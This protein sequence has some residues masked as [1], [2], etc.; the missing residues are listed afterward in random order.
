VLVLALRAY[1]LAEPVTVPEDLAGLPEDPAAG[2][3]S[4]P[5]LSA[6]AFEARYNGVNGALPGGLTPPG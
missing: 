2:A 6:K 4:E 1:R 3:A 5:A